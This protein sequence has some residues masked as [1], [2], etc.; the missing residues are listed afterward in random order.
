ML[1]PVFML[2]KKDSLEKLHQARKNARHVST[3]CSFEV[4]KQLKAKGFQT[5]Q[6]EGEADVE[7]GEFSSR[8]T[9]VLGDDAD[10]LVRG[11]N[12]L[13]RDFQ[14][15][16]TLYN[17]NDIKK[18]AKLTTYQLKMMVCMAG[19][20]YVDGIKN[21]GIITAYDFVKKYSTWDKVWAEVS[22][23]F[24]VEKDDFTAI[25]SAILQF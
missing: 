13:L 10:L 23:K 6:C 3:E 8:Y 25:Q 19:C 12:N 18:H 1:L 11:V 4:L 2:K 24:A 15:G 5:I 21:M 20:D 17:A 16:N 14:K 9:Y 7:L 22:K